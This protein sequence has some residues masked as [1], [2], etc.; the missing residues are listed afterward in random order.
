MHGSTSPPKNG[1]P[2]CSQRQWSLTNATARRTR[3]EHGSTPKSRSS[4]SVGSVAV[5]GWPWFSSDWLKLRAGKHAPPAHWP[6]SPC[7]GSRWPRAP[8]DARFFFHSSAYLVSKKTQRTQR[9]AKE[10]F[11]HSLD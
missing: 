11:F 6:S 2:A 7:G 10:N 8:E 4:W 3:S 9:C 5:Q 1:C